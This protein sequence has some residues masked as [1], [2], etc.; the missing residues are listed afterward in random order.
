MCLG[1]NKITNM[2]ET[3]NFQNH[4]RYF[5]LFHFVIF[6]LLALNLIWQGI[7]L[8]LYPSWNQAAFIVLSVVFILMILAARLQSLKVQD[9]VIRL[10]ERIRYGELLPAYM[11]KLTRDLSIGQIIALRFASDEE[12]PDLVRR[13][14]DGEFATTTDIK[15]AIK[16]WRA[17]FLRA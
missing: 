3:Q 16:N 14:L 6:P 2:N 11:L 5:P 12:L 13:T 10:E 1:R 15:K 8:Y 17:D 9:R 7:M 4:A